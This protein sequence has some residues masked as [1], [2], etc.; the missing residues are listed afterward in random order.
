M[1]IALEILFMTK[2]VFHALLVSIFRF[3]IP[4]KRKSVKNDIVL[5]TGSAAGI[6]RQ[7]A[8]EFGKLEAIVVLWDINEKENEETARKI[9]E[10]GG[11]SHT[12]TCDVRYIITFLIHLAHCTSSF[13]NIIFCSVSSVPTFLFFFSPLFCV[14]IFVSEFILPRH[15]FGGCPSAKGF[16]V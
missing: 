7:L 10:L 6:G 8:V 13:I 9:K 11:R 16:I 3:F 14:N 15:L 1:N 2:N 12:Y 4:P 5:I